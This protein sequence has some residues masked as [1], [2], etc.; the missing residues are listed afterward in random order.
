MFGIDFKSFY[1]ILRSEI[2]FLFPDFTH[3]CSIS[4]SA[5]QK[6]RGQNDLVLI[7]QSL[8]HLCSPL[9]SPLSTP[10][11]IFELQHSLIAV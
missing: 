3:Q 5:E 10:E 8:L 6:V 1:E 2:M 7:S 11:Y 9:N 4:R